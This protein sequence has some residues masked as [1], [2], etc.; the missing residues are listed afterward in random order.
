MRNNTTFYYMFTL[1]LFF[2]CAC[3]KNKEADVQCRLTEI[4]PSGLHYALTYENNNMVSMGEG[5]ISTMIYYNGSG[6]ITKMEM[7]LKEPY[8][9]IEFTYAPNGKVSER[10]SFVKRGV[11]WVYE[12]K[13]NLI[14][15]NNQ[16]TAM[17][18][19]VQMD[20]IYSFDV[21]WSGG[22]ITSITKRFTGSTPCVYTYQ[23]DLTKINNLAATRD[24]YFK[25]VDQT[26]SGY[27]MP[28]Y[29]SKNLLIK[30]E[31]SC[32]LS[33][34]HLFSYSFTNEG[35]IDQVLADGQMIWSYAYDCK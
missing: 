12:G 6:Q 31:G 10:K 7:P 17:E 23:Y 13:Q 34:T 15:T 1:A 16:L 18:G 19:Y 9:R 26:Y 24:L 22:N 29:L 14:Y 27:K 21:V 4:N 11:D 35:M 30:A 28:F 8:S 2:V 5:P 20:R 33:E 25:D 3:K 32:A